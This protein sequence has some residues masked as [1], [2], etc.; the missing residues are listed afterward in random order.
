MPT[1]SSSSTRARS[2]ARNSA[3]GTIRRVSFRWFDS[4][5]GPWF[6]V[7]G[8]DGGCDGQLTTDNGLKSNEFARHA[9][10]LRSQLTD[11]EFDLSPWRAAR[12]AYARDGGHE[13]RLS[14]PASGRRAQERH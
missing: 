5:R 12:S 2:S 8:A 10:E 4:V 9:P 13:Q 11:L 1:A 14:P 6:V 7:R 3:S